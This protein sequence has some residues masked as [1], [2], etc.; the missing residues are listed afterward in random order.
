MGYILKRV[1]SSNHYTVYD[2]VNN[3]VVEFEE[4]KFN[5]SQKVTMLEDDLHPDAVKLA[6]VMRLLTDWLI[7]NH[8]NIL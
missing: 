2:D 5:D 3:I 7:E 8:K 6:R 4:H 1:E